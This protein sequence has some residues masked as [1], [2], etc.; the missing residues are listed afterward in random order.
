MLVKYSVSDIMQQ[1]LTYLNA[2]TAITNFSA[3]S[4]ARSI[5]ESI[6]PEI[7]ESDDEKR[8]SLYSFMEEVLEQGFI[9]QAKGPY[10][11][12]MGALFSFPR[13]YEQVYEEEGGKMTQRLIDDETYRAEIL[14]QV[15]SIMS[16]NYTSLRFNLLRVGGVE[17]IIPMEYALGT[18]SFKFIIIP[19][20]N[21]PTQELLDKCNKVVDQYKA[22]G[23]R[24]LLEFPTYVRVDLKIELQFLSS[25]PSNKKGLI[26]E[27]VRESIRQ[28]LLTMPMAGVLVYND[29][30]QKIMNI[31]DEIYDFT[32]L[33]YAIN[34][35]PV[36]LS[37][38]ELDEEE[39]FSAGT[40]EITYL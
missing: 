10:L 30:V 25:T 20:I 7:G 22:F 39:R 34:S 14:Q 2:N 12:L 38:Q 11:D 23:V 1:A 16:A 31:S 18:G 32:V 13:R 29:I 28:H 33:H 3:G 21:E 9:S 35:Y 8:G 26:R 27:A 36:M 40:I 24:P 37:N 15:M 5:I 19:D 17:D 4:I 6:A